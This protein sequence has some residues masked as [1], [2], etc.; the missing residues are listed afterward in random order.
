MGYTFAPHFL[1]HL[2]SI[3][4]EKMSW[5]LYTESST[6]TYTCTYTIYIHKPIMVLFPIHVIQARLHTSVSSVTKSSIIC[7]FFCQSKC[8]KHKWISC[9]FYVQTKRTLK[10]TH[11]KVIYTTTINNVGVYENFSKFQPF[12]YYLKC[13]STRLG[14]YALNPIFHTKITQFSHFTESP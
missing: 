8:G 11:R 13:K 6:Q 12:C 7:W 4:Y 2:S 9:C 5:T 14:I 3:S 1:G 10:K